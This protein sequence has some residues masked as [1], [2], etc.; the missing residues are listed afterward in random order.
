MKD[1]FPSPT[2]TELE[3]RGPNPEPD[4]FWLQV[5]RNRREVASWPEWKRKH[6]DMWYEIYFKGVTA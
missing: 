4:T 5:E 2:K 3:K 1:L 6:A